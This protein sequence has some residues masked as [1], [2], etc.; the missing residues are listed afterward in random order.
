[1][2]Y[3][4]ITP[5]TSFEK[6]CM[7]FITVFSSIVFGYMIS[8]IGSIF[9]Q[10]KEDNEKYLN[11]MAVINS[12]LKSRNVSP[13]LQLR[14]RIYFEYYLRLNANEEEMQNMIK[15]ITPELQGE[16]RIDLYAKH[17]QNVNFIR[18]GLSEQ[19]LNKLCMAVR[20]RKLQPDE[21]VFKEDDC[22]DKLVIL[23]SGSLQSFVTL[24]K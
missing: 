20:E 10:L 14:V 13:Q 11:K 23:I 6:G 5:E 19:T 15:T 12:F 9:S 2:G 3:G 21:I 17:L 18:D 8:S 16:V 24:K 4:D 7:V 1:V 22:V